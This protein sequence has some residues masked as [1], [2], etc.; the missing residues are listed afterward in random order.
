MEKNIDTFLH[1]GKGKAQSQRFL[2][3]LNPE[4]FE[5]HDFTVTDWLLFAYNFAQHINYFDFPEI[6]YKL[7]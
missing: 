1:Y 5:L 7:D 4:S 2:E 3:E 6:I